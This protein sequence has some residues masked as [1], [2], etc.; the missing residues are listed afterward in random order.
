MIEAP[1]P[2]PGPVA[3]SVVLI[4]ALVLLVHL[5]VFTQ[6]AVPVSADPVRSYPWHLHAARSLSV[7]TVPLWNPYSLAGA[8]F[9]ADPRSAVYDPLHWPA[10][11]V[12]SP[13]VFAAAIPARAVLAG[14]LMAV[15]L[16]GL[17]LSGAAVV[18]G[19]ALFAL[20]GAMTLHLG[21]PQA[22]AAALLPLVMHGAGAAAARPGGAPLLLLGF[23]GAAQM[24]AGDPAT[25]LMSFAAA[26]AWLAWCAAGSP[27]RGAAFWSFA[28]GMVLA[29]AMASVQMVPS[30]QYAL[31]SV[32]LPGEGPGGGGLA[33]MHAGSLFGGGALVLAVASLRRWRRA[34]VFLVLAGA[35]C[36]AALLPRAS[37]RPLLLLGFAEAALAAMALGSIQAEG[38]GGDRRGPAWWLA[39]LAAGAAVTALL[40]GLQTDALGSR[41]ALLAPS[42]AAA[43]LA[44]ALALSR[45]GGGIL[46][47]ALALLI[48]GALGHA[49]DR[50]NP[51][52]DPRRLFAPGPL[53][54]FLRRDAASDMARGGRMA[55][56]GSILP[57]ESHMVYRIPS[58]QGRAGMAPQACGPLLARAGLE[59]LRAGEPIDAGQRRLLDALGMRWIAA[60][61]EGPVPGGSLRPAYDGPDGRVFVNDAAAPRFSFVESLRPEPGLPARDR[62]GAAHDAL[63][64]GAPSAGA[65]AEV[66]VERDLAGT[67]S[68][69]VSGQTRPGWLLVRDAYAP[70]WK[71][72]VN[73]ERAAVRRAEE[74]FRAIAVPAGDALVEMSYRPTGHRAG[75]WISALALLAALGVGLAMLGQRLD[76]ARRCL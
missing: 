41:A 4:A 1:G 18:A 55:G 45:R 24:L 52:A 7:G 12:P 74:C 57:P 29:G 13:R 69:R 60:P 6:G 51:E 47:G 67:L 34:I 61:P 10:W 42:L 28:G 33:A 58:L 54:D 3:V 30:L 20:G 15:F 32:T 38:A 64:P 9:A 65:G 2:R 8:P 68:V 44:A 17:G 40:S 22:N 56:V 26:G 14:A 53:T 46:A 70:G 31:R 63:P 36:A 27:R 25:F 50:A 37:S 19:S 23:A 76:A 11:I 5:P 75:V 16:R 66:T 48:A 62:G 49:A 71:A 72:S 59:R 35:S 39:W 43:A 73:G 21:S